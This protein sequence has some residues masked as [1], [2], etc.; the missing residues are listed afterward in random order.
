MKKLISIL[1]A[2]ALCFAA[3]VPAYATETTEATEPMELEAPPTEIY[4]AEELAA[5]AENPEGNYILMAD[6]DMTGI[7]WKGLDFAGTFDG[8]GHAILNLTL[9]QPGDEMPLSYDGNSKKYETTYYGLFATMRNA[10]VKNLKLLNVRA[11]VETDS[12]CFVAGIAGFMEYSTISDCTVEGTLELRA[13]DRMFGVGGI[14]GYGCGTVERCRADVTLICV[15]T[16]AATRDEQFL[17]G[18]YGTGFIAVY[19]SEIILDGY[20][21]EHGYVHSGGVVGMYMRYPYG[22][23]QKGYICG[24]S[25]TGKITFFEHNSDRRAYCD[26]YCG[27]NMAIW[28]ILENNTDDFVEDERFQYDV[29]LRPEMCE[30]PVYT[31]TLIPSGCDTYGFTEYTCQ[32]CGYTYRDHYTLTQHTVTQW[33]ILVAPTTESEGLSVGYCDGCG[34]EFQRTEETL[35]PEP[36]TEPE[37]VPAETQ[38]APEE[39]PEQESPN[40]WPA[41]AALALILPAAFI[42]MKKKRNKE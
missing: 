33:S 12:P 3:A 17:G 35:P 19:D 38:P 9:A 27:E 20:I 8:N 42:G 7:A 10:E 15:D 28:L 40:R 13:H 22:M 37:T 2:L 24:T 21:S 29:E 18:V 1:M 23:K 6:L 25:V 11:L 31:E 36:S 41:A 30:A 34:M 5:I 39:E 16:D 4:T 26:A 32:T 14:A